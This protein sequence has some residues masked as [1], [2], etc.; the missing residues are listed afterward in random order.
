MNTTPL[1]ITSFLGLSRQEQK[2]VTHLLDAQ[3][4][5]RDR[6]LEETH[7]NTDLALGPRK[8]LR[9]LL[10]LKGQGNHHLVGILRQWLETPEG[11]L[12]QSY[13]KH[14]ERT[15]RPDLSRHAAA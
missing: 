1:N 2:L 4:R 3:D 11:S 15:V 7:E 5:L 13:Q 8:R 6:P 10:A 14:L 12:L 9:L